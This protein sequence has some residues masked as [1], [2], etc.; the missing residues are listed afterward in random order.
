[1]GLLRLVYNAD[2]AL[3][4]SESA[5]RSVPASSES[6]IAGLL[7]VIADSVRLAIELM[8]S[9]WRAR[10]PAFGVTPS[11]PI[12]RRSSPGLASV[13]GVC[14]HRIGDS[15]LARAAIWHRPPVIRKGD[16]RE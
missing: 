11:T 5:W 16:Y 2:L 8:P 9:F 4:L 6:G 7:S 12:C 15:Q 10:E 13:A 14:E 3:I 1:M